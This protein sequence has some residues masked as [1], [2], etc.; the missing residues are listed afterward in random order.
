MFLNSTMR[1]RIMLALFIGLLFFACKKELGDSILSESPDIVN[2]Q[3]PTGD[4]VSLEAAKAAFK[5]K[6]P[7]V[8]SFGG[9]AFTFS[10]DTI[11]PLWDFVDTI[12]Y[13][14]SIP[15]LT[16]PVDRKSLT[17]MEA[18]FFLIF[19]KQPNDSIT[20]R[21]VVVQGADGYNWSDQYLENFTGGLFQFDAYSQ[22]VNSYKFENGLI[23]GR[24]HLATQTDD[25]DSEQP[26]LED[27]FEFYTTLE[28]PQGAIDLYLDACAPIGGGGVNSGSNPGSGSTPG[29]GSNNSG[30]NNNGGSNNGG[31]GI[32]GQDPLG[33]GNT[34]F[35][36]N[37][38]VNPTG[39]G[40]NGDGSSIN[41]NKISDLLTDGQESFY[42]YK[43]AEMVNEFK[44]KN[45]LEAS[46]P[47][48]MSQIT[49]SCQLPQDPEEMF[50]P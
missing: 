14:D 13:K 23:T 10:F 1:L 11:H 31:S 24:Y 29:S 38:W 49:Q 26:Q 2:T 17:P 50:S 5:T 21:L 16:V 6:R 12:R 22:M 46:G 4:L 18:D 30:G 35:S 36:P 33:W 20:Y 44:R 9:G 47:E 42:Y 40:S 3:S 41:P 32:Y 15:V 28:L 48:L 19:L 7:P 43:I 27:C 25:R 37:N 8:Q 34:T 45:C 39:T